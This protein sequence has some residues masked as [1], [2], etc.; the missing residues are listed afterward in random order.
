MAANDPRG[1][2]TV[3]T[4]RPNVRFIHLHPVQSLMVVWHAIVLNVLFARALQDR[5][6]VYYSV[7]RERC[8]PGLLLFQSETLAKYTR[9]HR[10]RHHGEMSGLDI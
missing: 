8:Q 9:E 2:W 5:P 6:A 3:V 10:Q 1:P 7:G 4:T